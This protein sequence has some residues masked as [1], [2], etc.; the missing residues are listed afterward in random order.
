MWLELPHY[1]ADVLQLIKLAQISAS[2]NDHSER[3]CDQ[4]QQWLWLRFDLHNK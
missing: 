3:E 1:I 4:L 2:W